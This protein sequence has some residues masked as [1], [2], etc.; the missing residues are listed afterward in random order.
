MRPT[1]L[2]H[3][4]IAAEVLLQNLL[5]VEHANLVILPATIDA[6]DKGLGILVVVALP[7]KL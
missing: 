6:H 2:L 5:L 3:A 1:P 7:L 4:Q